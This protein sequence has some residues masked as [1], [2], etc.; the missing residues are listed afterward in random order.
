MGGG[1]GGGGIFTENVL[2][3]LREGRVEG[4]GER[5][6]LKRADGEQRTEQHSLREKL[7]IVRALENAV[8]DK[9]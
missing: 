3:E 1:G 9:D 2:E 4:V 8:A 5:G 7:E 6:R